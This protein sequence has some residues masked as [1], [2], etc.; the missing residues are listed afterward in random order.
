MKRALLIFLAAIMVISLTGCSLVRDAYH[1]IVD[2]KPSSGPATVP[3]DAFGTEPPAPEPTEDN[4]DNPFDG[5]FGDDTPEPSDP[6]P[7]PAGEEPDTPDT[8]AAQEG[9]VLYET[10]DFKITLVSLNLDDSYKVSATVKVENYAGQPL[11]FRVKDTCVNG[12]M[13]DAYLFVDLEDGKNATDDITI[14]NSDMERYGIDQFARLEFKF[15][16]YDEDYGTFAESKYLSLVAP[17]MED[18]VQKVATDGV[19]IANDSNYH[20]VAV[21]LDTTSSENYKYLYIYVQNKTSDTISFLSK[22]VYVNDSAID[23]YIGNSTVGAG[24]AGYIYLSLENKKL[25]EN[26]IQQVDEIE[27]DLRVI[28]AED[29]S[30]IKDITKIQITVNH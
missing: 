29:Y 26:N 8:P 9:S 19:E 13:C 4:G 17:G 5:I 22:N 11:K 10:K 24:K 14:Y 30:T 20:I 3:P 25:E 1:E 16:I 2:D 15:L 6:T 7:E 27:F 12:L 23:A 18:Y 21:T 28:S